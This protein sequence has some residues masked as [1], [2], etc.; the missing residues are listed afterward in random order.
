M[1]GLII[2]VLTPECVIASLHMFVCLYDHIFQLSTMR[3]RKLLKP[4]IVMSYDTTIVWPYDNKHKT[5]TAMQLL[6]QTQ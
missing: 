4:C 5:I 1:H 2:I 6:K 3:L